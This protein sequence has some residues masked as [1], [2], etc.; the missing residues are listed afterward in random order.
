MRMGKIWL[1]ALALGLATP[2]AAQVLPPGTVGLTTQYAAACTSTSCA[3][4]TLTTAASV[5]VSV[6]GTC[7]S[8]VLTW[9]GSSDGG[10]TFFTVALINLASGAT[11]TTTAA[12]GQFAIANSGLTHLQARLTTLGSGGFNVTAV[13]GYASARWLTPFL[14]SLYAT[15][16]AITAATATGTTVNDP[17]EV[18]ALT[19]KVTLDKTAFVCAATTCDVTIGTL[20]ANTWL[21]NVTAALT[22][23]FAC[24]ATCTSSTL[25]MI[26]GKGAGGSEYLASLDA[27]AAVAIFGDADAELGTA[28][29]RAAAVQGGTF[30]SASQAVVLRLT[31]GTGNIGNG[32]VTNLSQ[33]SI[34]VYLTTRVLP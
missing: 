22:Q 19:Y 26:L 30:T 11:A 34:T 14:L 24:T 2:A 28:M 25:S 9:E 15:S 16:P 8:C 17:G 10:K 13:R 5:T 33:G 23:T 31:S 1:A 4:W 21:V 6:T 7:T 12:T 29:V 18:R 32:T 20:P 3:T 27:D